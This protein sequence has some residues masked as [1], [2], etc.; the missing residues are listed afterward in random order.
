MNRRAVL[1]TCAGA[2]VSGTLLFARSAISGDLTVSAAGRAGGSAERG[3]ARAATSRANAA[4]T[5]A[6]RRSPSAIGAWKRPSALIE[7][8]H[9][10]VLRAARERASGALV[11]ARADARGRGGAADDH[12]A[13]HAA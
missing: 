5:K 2:P 6:R 9:R 8:H 12:G 3:S 10:L 1:S 4:A 13:A 11:A 7:A